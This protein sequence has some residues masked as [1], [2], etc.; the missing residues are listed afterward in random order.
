[1]VEMTIREQMRINPL[2]PL[3][4]PHGCS[5]DTTLGGYF[6]PKGS[7]VISN[8]YAMNHDPTVWKDPE[9]FRPERFLEPGVKDTTFPFGLGKK[10][11][12][13]MLKNG[14]SEDFSEIF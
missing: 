4:V 5:E 8:L 6:V 13:L 2:T 11:P 12:L 3:G 14:S 7:L 1:M 10:V 9:S